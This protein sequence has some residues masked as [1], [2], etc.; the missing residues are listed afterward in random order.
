LSAFFPK[1]WLQV[2]D[3]DLSEAEQGW[4][5]A[6]VSY[7][8]MSLGRLTEA[9]PVR[10]ASI[11][12]DVK[13]KDWNSA[14]ISAGNLTDLLL[15][16]GK[17]HEAEIAARL[18][19][20]YALHSENKFKQWKSYTRLA[21]IL[22][23]LGKL[24]QAQ[25]IFVQADQLQQQDH[26]DD[27][28][29]YSIHGAWYC[30]LLLDTARN[31][32]DLEHILE[33]GHYA[34]K[35]AQHQNKLLDMALGHLTLARTYHVLQQLQTASTEFKLAIQAIQKAGSIDETPPF[36]LA[37]ASF[38]LSQ[39]ELV[40]AKDDID[41]A[42]QTITRCG[43]KLYAVDA[44]LLLGRYYLAMHDKATAQSYYDQAAMLIVETGYH[45]RDKDLIELK[46]GL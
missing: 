23:R 27:I 14:A 43:M 25:Q 4:L 21:T 2:V 44:A 29:L 9:V 24:E 34:L 26:T 15:P 22:H 11:K 19:M 36:Y 37:H 42:N 35:T 13:L 8:L 12:I 32:T 18:T 7:C 38:H 16:L 39:N 3:T 41:T 40:K 30:A 45:L 46:R 6:E 33:R 10:E 17:L 31:S 20:E 5:L 1:S 28:Y